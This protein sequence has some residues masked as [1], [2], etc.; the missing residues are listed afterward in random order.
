MGENDLCTMGENGLRTIRAN[1]LCTMG[2]NE[3]RTMREK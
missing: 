1:R 2:E 3:L